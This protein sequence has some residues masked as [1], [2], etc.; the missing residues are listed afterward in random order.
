MRRH[1]LSRVGPRLGFLIALGVLL[2][3]CRVS[4]PAAEAA[5]GELEQ[6]AGQ[7]GGITTASHRVLRDAAAWDAFWPGVQ[8]PAPRSLDP[9]REQAVAVFL[10]ERRTGGYNVRIESATAR[11]GRLIVTYRESP[12]P[13]GTMV[14]QALS[15]PW[16]LVVVP[17]SDL[18]VEVRP[19]APPPPSPAKK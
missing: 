18:A 11:E 13:A 6:W 8:T 5:S 10:G 17:R 9:A 4:E 2:G 1:H 15:S 16:A 14:T 3:A 19:V 12:P 7:Q